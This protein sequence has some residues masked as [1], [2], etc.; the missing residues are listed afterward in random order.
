MDSVLLACN[1]LCHGASYLSAG[2]HLWQALLLCNCVQRQ[3]E[4]QRGH[5]A[6]QLQCIW[7]HG[8]APATA[9]AGHIACKAPAAVSW[10]MVLQVCL[11][12]NNQYNSFG[13]HGACDH[14]NLRHFPTIETCVEYL[15]QCGEYGSSR[16]S[17]AADTPLRWCGPACLMTLRSSVAARLT[18]W[19][20]QQGAPLWGW[21]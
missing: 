2:Q 8:G 6:A 18:S 19:L 4:T 11:V 9:A 14:V 1:Q 7:C 12:G 20:L 5:L 10:N 16:A 21:R 15:K 3:Q 13:S 17:P